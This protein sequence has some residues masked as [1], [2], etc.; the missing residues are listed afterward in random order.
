[1]GQARRLIA[2]P[3]DR[4]IGLI[5]GVGFQQQLLDWQFAHDAAQALRPLMRDRPADADAK[6]QLEQLRGL[7]RAAGKAVHH[8]AQLPAAVATETTQQAMTRPAP[9]GRRISGNR[10]RGPA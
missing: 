2:L 9:C 10:I 4:G 1:M 5:R 3:A 8:A 7:L 6:A